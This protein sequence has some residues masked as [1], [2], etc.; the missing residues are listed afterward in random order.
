MNY[1]HLACGQPA[2]LGPL[3]QSCGEPLHWADM[4]AARTPKYQ[5]ERDARWEAFKARR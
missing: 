3:C 2:G 1:T 5:K 4:S